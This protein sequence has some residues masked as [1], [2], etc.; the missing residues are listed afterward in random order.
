MT[1]LAKLLTNPLPPLADM[2]ETWLIFAADLAADLA[3]AQSPDSPHRAEPIPLTDGRLALCA[4]LLSEV[5]IGGIFAGPFAALD[6]A[7]FAMVEVM[8]DEDFRALL[9]LTDE[10]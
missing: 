10:P 4:D 3:A 6:S 2:R 7:K 9:P 5:S 8:G 1:T